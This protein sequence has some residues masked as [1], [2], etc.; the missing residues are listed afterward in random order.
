MHCTSS[1]LACT[2]RETGKLED[3]ALAFVRAAKLDYDNA[4]PLLLEAAELSTLLQ[5][6]DRAERLYKSALDHPSLKCPPEVLIKLAIAR[7]TCGD[8]KNLCAYLLDALTFCFGTAAFASAVPAGATSSAYAGRDALMTANV[9]MGTLANGAQ[10]SASESIDLRRSADYAFEISQPLT[11]V[12]TSAASA[13]ATT[14]GNA[15]VLV[16]RELPP[17]PDWADV[18]LEATNYLVDEYARIGQ[19]AAIVR[20]LNIA[21]A[22]IRGPGGRSEGLPLDLVV[23]CAVARLHSDDVTAA[24]R[25]LSALAAEPTTHVADL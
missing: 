15:A 8:V 11:A 23:K 3:A 1:T 10:F 9:V 14:D 7:N 2:R 5:K 4:L 22:F 17:R 25:A 13:T 19:H 18:A 24:Q 16:A 21:D 12:V 6:H 20:L